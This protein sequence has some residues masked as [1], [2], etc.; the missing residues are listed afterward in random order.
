MPYN[1]KSDDEIYPDCRFCNR[2]C[3]AYANEKCMALESLDPNWT[4]CPF[5]KTKEQYE[6]EDEKAL[7][8]LREKRMTGR[9]EYYRKEKAND[10]DKPQ[11]Q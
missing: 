1:K 2:N 6:A 3:H 10:A 5:F 11:K 7:A 9:L 8:R 4:Y